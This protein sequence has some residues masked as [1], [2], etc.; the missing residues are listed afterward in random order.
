MP[1]P[2]TATLA[3]S[4]GSNP[5]IA[6]WLFVDDH[7]GGRALA[8]P[9]PRIGEE[10]D[11]LYHHGWVVIDGVWTGNTA[12]VQKA[13]PDEWAVLVVDGKI[14]HSDIYGVFATQDDAQRYADSLTLSDTGSAHVI[15]V[16]APR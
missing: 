16:T 1:K 9:V 7:E 4:P 2:Y 5:Q 11:L 14:K 3:P 13:T 12:A 10:D 6:A 8:V 15:S